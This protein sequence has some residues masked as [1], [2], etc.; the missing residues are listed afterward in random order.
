MI[1]KFFS[2]G[3]V[4]GGGSWGDITGTLSSQTDLQSALDAKFS[5]GTSNELTLV[6]N[7]GSGTVKLRAADFTSD[8]TIL[9][10]DAAPPVDAVKRYLGNSGS[11]PS[12]LFWYS[13]AKGDVGLGNV[14]N[15]SDANK[16]V[17]TA[18]QTALDLKANITALDQKLD[19][20]L[21]FGSGQDGALSISSGTTTLNRDR[22]Y[23][24]IT[25][26]GTAK[27]STAGF[28]VFCSGVLNLSAAPLAAIEDITTSGSNASGTAAGAQAGALTAAELGR[29]NRGVVGVAG[30]ATT[31]TAGTAGGATAVALC[32]VPAGQGGAGGLGASGAGGARGAAPTITARKVAYRWEPNLIRGVTLASGGTNGSAGGSG[33]GDTTAGGG[34]GAS[35]SGG[36]VVYIAAHTINRGGSTAAGAIRCIGGNGGNGGVPA[37]GNRGGGGGG[38]GGAGG[39]IQIVYTELTGSTATNMIL[40]SGGNGGNGGNATGTGIGGNGGDGG[41]GGVIVLINAG[42]GATTTT[43]G[44]ALVAGSTT[45]NATGAAGGTGQVTQASL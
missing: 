16:P 5:I 12:S 7:G 45:A 31:G 35:G 17:S 9:F 13:I 44:T 23:S 2:P 25:I 38:A 36:G 6:E 21:L 11:D 28:R 3:G 26:T 22:Y 10:P 8:Y 40:A 42:S 4:G 30:G 32:Q 14:D 24:S 27:L 37:G 34:S 29:G 19:E 39:Y 20:D 1:T 33:G 43:L 15:T 18:T 41:P